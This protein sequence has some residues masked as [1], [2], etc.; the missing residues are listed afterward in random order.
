MKKL[1]CASLAAVL[2]MLFA[3]R[4]ADS[5][6]TQDPQATAGIIQGGVL[7]YERDLRTNFHARERVAGAEV[8]ITG[9]DIRRVV[10]TGTSGVFSF[11]NLPLETYTVTCKL[12]QPNLIPVQPL[13]REVD[14][15]RNG[16]A[17]FSFAVY[18]DGG[19]RGRIVQSSQTG[20][21]RF[22]M[23]LVLASP[24]YPAFPKAL[25]A[26]TGS[27]GRFEFDRIPPGR[28][29]L[30]IRLDGNCD[31][32]FP[33]PRTYYPGV[34]G[35]EKAAVV[36]LGEGQWIDVGDMPAPMP[37][38]TRVAEGNVVSKDGKPPASAIVA[39]DLIEY[40][41]TSPGGTTAAGT[42]AFSIK[43]F[44]GLKYRIRAAGVFDG[45]PVP[46]RSAAVELSRNGSVSDVRLVLST[47]IPA[48]NLLQD[49][50][51]GSLSGWTF[52]GD[53][54]AERTRFLI[55][56]GGRA[57]QDIVLPQN[58]TGKYLLIFGW[59]SSEGIDA[60]GATT[61]QPTLS[62]YLMAPTGGEINIY[63]QGAELRYLPRTPNTRA[64]AYGIF[65][66]VP[67]SGRVRLFLGQ[68]Q[69][70]GASLAGSAARFEDLGLYLFDSGEEARLYLDCCLLKQ[71]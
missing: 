8:T 62:G 36:A 59:L 49:P 54:S 38:A 10:T 32:G 35:M 14:L 2:L 30:G 23:D 47:P 43:L 71:R 1:F 55:R 29:L 11:R 60:A 16:T 22:R 25:Y 67:N 50:L 41:Y 27:D 65:Q 70:R 42:G 46:M 13:T 9:K 17:F 39:L 34:S 24:E 61:G 4:I 18:N 28:Y 19:I 26:Y 52:Q 56:N 5:S 7:K 33:Y 48:R 12:P 68:A 37:L 69:T 66:V 63:L 3:V 51:P 6:A 57:M 15:R 53:A 45:N 21:Y 20:A 40:P 31:A 58:S 44:E 64:P